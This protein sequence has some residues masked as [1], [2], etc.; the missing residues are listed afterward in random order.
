V[1]FFHVSPP[2]SRYLSPR[3]HH[4][5]TTLSVSPYP[6]LTTRAIARSV[7]DVVDV[8]VDI[9]R[10]RHRTTPVTSSLFAMS[11]STTR[12]SNANAR[13][14]ARSLGDSGR[15]RRRAGARARVPARATRDA[16]SRDA[17]SRA[18]EDGGKKEKETIGRRRFAFDV[19]FVVAMAKEFGMATG[20]AGASEDASEGG[21]ASDAETARAMAEP[22][23]TEDA[24]SAYDQMT[25]TGGNSQTAKALVAKGSGS[26]ASGAKATEGG[27]GA[28][29]AAIPVVLGVAGFAAFKA[30]SGGGNDDGDDDRDEVVAAT[31]V[32]KKPAAAA[33]PK[34]ETPKAETPKP[35]AETPKAETP[36]P[37]AETPKPKVEAPKM[38][39]PK[40]DMPKFEKPSFGKKMSLP[41]DAPRPNFPSRADASWNQPE[42]EE[43]AVVEPVVKGEAKEKAEDFAAVLKEKAAQAAAVAAEKA[44]VAAAQLEDKRAQQ[45]AEQAE[46]DRSAEERDAAERKQREKQLIEDERARIKAEKADRAEQQRL[47]REEARERREQEKAERA[48]E[49]AR[50]KE[51]RAS[52]RSADKEAKVS[53]RSVIKKSEESAPAAPSFPGFFSKSVDV[54][55]DDEPIAAKTQIIKPPA[56]QVKPEPTQ[57][58]KIAKP[59]LS[60]S[61]SDEASL[62]AN[63]PTVADLQGLD[64]QAKLELADEA[65][66][67]AERLVAKA[68]A[69]E[70]FAT[71]AVVS[72][73]FFLKSGAQKQAVRARETADLA[74]EEARKVRAASTSSGNGAL[75][76]G[77]VALLVVAGAAAFALSSGGSLPSFESVSEPSTTNTVKIAQSN[78]RA[79]ANSP[80]FQGASKKAPALRDVE[81]AR[82]MEKVASGEMD[83]MALYEQM[84]R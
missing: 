82:A 25:R 27:S 75:V 62:P 11:T 55:S 30:L 39:M 76:G 74:V 32:M 33:A 69:A 66:Q 54:D 56:R 64:A 53:S 36:K 21:A 65:E 45:A 42:V 57:T 23:G 81:A 5:F 31:Q 14:R 22:R 58:K 17:R 67:Y 19:A 63:F 26:K 24:L 43:A 29:L 61:P 78:P 12:A 38:E 80:S 52:Q 16:R 49:R 60:K 6:Y 20:D 51:A 71:G 7:D 72:V 34:A 70:K 47:E 10:A 9:A 41:P 37:K 79:K 1:R 59:A 4:V 50:E 68:D 83:A 3:F 35:K 28:P 13:A 8:D 44:K 77:V 40:M 46:R 2:F 18:S 48:E 73:L 84:R 15:I